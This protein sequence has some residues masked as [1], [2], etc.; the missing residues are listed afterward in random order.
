[1]R[2]LADQTYAE[3]GGSWSVLTRQKRDHEVLDRLLDQVGTTT[4]A[5]QEAALHRVY[6]LVFSH[7]FAEESVLW[8]ALRRALPDGEEVTA[9]V[10]REHQEITELVARLE[11]SDPDD[12][13]RPA[14]LDA[15]T[16]VLRKDVR[17]EEDVL[18]PRLQEVLDEGGLRRLGIAW[19]AVRRVAPTRTHPIVSRRPPGNVLAALPLSLIDRTRDGL[20]RV[21]RRSTPRV[22]GLLEAASRGLGAT[23]RG[24]E[25]LPPLRAGERNDTRT[26]GGSNP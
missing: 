13:E 14:L 25:R 24:V 26:E 17:D 19:E 10:E 15:T 16:E 1:M 2:S 11:A 6:R 21:G 23:A 7:A 20:D 5:D 18:L 22:Q 3:L 9:Q 12:P 4:G 8:P